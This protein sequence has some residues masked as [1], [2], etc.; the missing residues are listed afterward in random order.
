MR[1]I[2]LAILGIALV[3]VGFGIVMT[4]VDVFFGIKAMYP[5]R[6]MQIWS[7]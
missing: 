6:W 5:F 3:I 1:T 7:L 2:I 4:F